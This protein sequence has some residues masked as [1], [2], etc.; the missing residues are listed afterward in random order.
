MTSNT[1]EANCT[2]PTNDVQAKFSLP[3]WGGVDGAFGD[4]VVS[5]AGPSP[6]LPL[7]EAYHSK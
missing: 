2:P 3:N 7:I 4:D 6:P 1:G 5:I